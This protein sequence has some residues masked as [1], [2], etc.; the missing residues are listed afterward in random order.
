V[1]LIGYDSIIE[2]EANINFQSFLKICLISIPEISDPYC[3]ISKQKNIL[4]VATNIGLSEPYATQRM[5]N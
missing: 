5:G 4:R 1:A 2:S 3:S